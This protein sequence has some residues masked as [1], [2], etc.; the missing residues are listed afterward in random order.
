[1]LLQ[2]GVGRIQSVKG[3][4]S[5]GRLPSDQGLQH[6]PFPDSLACWPARKIPDFANS[7][8]HMSQFCELRLSLALSLHTHML[9]VAGQ[10][11]GPGW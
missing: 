2:N 4:N 1:M 5:V 6:Q 3:L 10:Q 8:N 11:E 7:H 9:M